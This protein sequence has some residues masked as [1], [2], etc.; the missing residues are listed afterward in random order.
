MSTDNASAN[1]AWADFIEKTKSHW[2]KLHFDQGVLTKSISIWGSGFKLHEESADHD[3][4][5]K[6]EIVESEADRPNSFLCKLTNRNWEGNYMVRDD[7]D[8][9]SGTFGYNDSGGELVKVSLITPLTEIVE[10]DLKRF[11]VRLFVEGEDNQKGTLLGVFSREGSL[12]WGPSI[13]AEV[14]E[15]EMVK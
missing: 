10:K 9:E 7:R 2:F 8:E 1:D 14:L 15:I 12:F 4:H 13:K 3:Q 6:L 5:S 11:S